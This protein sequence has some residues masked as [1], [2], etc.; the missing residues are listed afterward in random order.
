MQIIIPKFKKSAKT[1]YDYFAYKV[2]LTEFHLIR[3]PSFLTI[4]FDVFELILNLFL[5]ISNETLLKETP[6]FADLF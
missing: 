5:E 3:C 1:K 4:I 6:L 2:A